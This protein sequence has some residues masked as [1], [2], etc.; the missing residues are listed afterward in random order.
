MPG[1][2]A[3]EAGSLCM[4]LSLHPA[5][6]SRLTQLHCALQTKG[7]YFRA[8]NIS[9]KFLNDAVHYN[10]CLHPKTNK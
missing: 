4:E 6:V 8:S 5:G 7:Q 10:A 3:E 9:T 1:Y 2:F